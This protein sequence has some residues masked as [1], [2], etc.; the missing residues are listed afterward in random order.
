[1]SNLRKKLAAKKTKLAK[2][3]DI[4]RDHPILDEMYSEGS[5][6]RIEVD[7]ILLDPD[8]PRKYFAKEALGEL[9]QS[10]KRNGILQPVLVRRD[11]AKIWLVAG[12][13]RYRAAKLAGLDTIP[14]VIT[15]GD[16]GEI[17]LIENI[18]REDLKPVE[19]AEAFARL[20]EH[21]QYRQEDLAAVIGKARSTVAEILS[22]NRLPDTIK[23]ECRRAD[24]YSR[25]LLVEVAKQKSEEKMISL[26]DQ[27]KKSDLDGSA[28]RKITR[29]A[30]EK[31]SSS[32]F[33][34]AL[35]KVKALKRC[36]GKINHLSEE[37]RT[38]LDQEL[39]LLN[40]VIKNLPPLDPAGN[41]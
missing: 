35:I 26:F 4:N 25:R 23:E 28:V 12:E 2:N 41:S 33:A 13:R 5:F 18:Q 9:A 38:E 34:K 1:M 14:A 32:L 37:E 40:V 22:L 19:E 3:P 21:H 8:Q 17:A 29:K 6:I 11:H 7:Q 36:L 27:V 39:E 10:I 30:G 16:P 20:M 31:E 15:T 24:N